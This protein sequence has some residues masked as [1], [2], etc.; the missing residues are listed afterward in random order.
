MAQTSETEESSDSKF[1][2]GVSLFNIVTYQYDYESAVAS[3]VLMTI[4]FSD[5]F[6]LEPSLGF[7]FSEEETLYS[8]EVGAFGKKTISKFNLL[9]GGRVGYGGGTVISVA[10]AVGGEYYFIDNFSVG[11]EVQLR[12]LFDED[13][14]VVFTNAAVLVRFYF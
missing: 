14:F 11:S 4:D 3:S 10:P 6:R 2:L 5:R 8:I 1:G 7:A 9:Y 12:S 13:N